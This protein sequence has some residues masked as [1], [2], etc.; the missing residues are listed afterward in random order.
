[1]AEVEFA[2][3]NIQR[4]RAG[5]PT[6]AY[7]RRHGRRWRLPGPWP[8]DPLSEEFLT[9]YHRLLAETEDPSAKVLDGF[10][11]GSFGTLVLQYF[12]SPEFRDRKPGTQVQYR[13]VLEKIALAHGAKPVKTLE[14]RHIKAWRDYLS[15][16]PG[17]ANMMVAVVRMLM[18]FAVDNDY[19]KDNPGKGIKL[20]KMG[21]HRAWT[22]EECEAFEARW[23]PGSMQR[24]AYALA[25]FTGQRRGDLAAMTR[26]HCKGGAIRV[27]QQKTTR[28][29]TTEEIWIP[30]H[31]ELADELERGARGEWLLA[32]ADGNAFDSEQLGH[33]FADAIEAAG[34]PEAC[35]THGLRKK[36]AQMLA[37]V[38]CSTLEI[39]AITGHRSL[40]EI[41]RYTKGARQRK[42]ATAAILRLEQNRD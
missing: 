42:L 33:W 3:V 10:P 28:G 27:M 13:R 6:Y 40:S 12:A 11:P 25:K 35:V 16:T 1:M 37:E 17:T 24:R 36:A 38:G 23:P 9:E 26:A 32:K 18:S 4:D 7:F 20:F 22:D 39:M 5:K 21:E 8:Q 41:E 19:R 15:D 14:R 29:R 2:Y 31:R 34:L 30:L